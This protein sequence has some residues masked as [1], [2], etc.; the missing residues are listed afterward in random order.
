MVVAQVKELVATPA[1]NLLFP[2]RPSGRPG[3]RQCVFPS[4]QS[5]RDFLRGGSST[6]ETSEVAQ[7]RLRLRRS[8][9]T[10]RKLGLVRPAAEAA[11]AAEAEAEANYSAAKAELV[12]SASASGVLAEGSSHADVEIQQDVAS[13]GWLVSEQKGHELFVHVIMEEL[14]VV[15]DPRH[16]QH[17]Y[18]MQHALHHLASAKAWPELHQLAAV[19]FSP[20]MLMYLVDSPLHLDAVNC[21]LETW[22]ETGLGA[23]AVSDEARQD[24]EGDGGGSGGDKNECNKQR[25]MV[26][27]VIEVLE[28]VRECHPG[29]LDRKLLK[30]A[31]AQQQQ[32][33]PEQAHKSAQTTDFPSM[34]LAEIPETLSDSLR[35][36]DLQFPRLMLTFGATA[37]AK[38]GGGGQSTLATSWQ[39]LQLTSYDEDA[40][41]HRGV[42]TCCAL[43][44]DGM[45]MVSGSRDRTIKIWDAESGRLRR[46]LSKQPPPVA[47]TVGGGFIAPDF[48]ATANNFNRTLDLSATGPAAA[49]LSSASHWRTVSCLAI[50]ADGRLV[51]SGSH[52]CTLKASKSVLL[53]TLCLVTAKLLHTFTLLHLLRSVC[54]AAL[55]HHRC[56]AVRAVTLHASCQ[57]PVFIWLYNMCSYV[58]SLLMLFYTFPVPGVGCVAGRA[59]GAAGVPRRQGSLLRHVF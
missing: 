38:G 47:A 55:L 32:L 29:F 26:E 20:R 27:N 17:M 15:T 53:P 54:T 6:A 11:V 24:G 39:Q 14:K 34:L 41:G 57:L 10:S 51:V 12:S 35:R 52:D 31:S 23:A 22:L 37:A 43:S 8:K 44:R 50:S 3:G 25:E 30:A 19:Q 1:M 9:R 56:R 13:S 42:V 28:F 21:K 5:V 7:L 18:A 2:L 48:G 4:H 58:A 49:L 59:R 46:T 36:L 40:A 33:K 45:T 16:V